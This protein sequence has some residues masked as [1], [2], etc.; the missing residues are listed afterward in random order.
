MKFSDFERLT[1]AVQYRVL[2][3]VDPGQGWSTLVEVL[4]HG[5]EG[6][7]S[8]ITDWL[9]PGLPADECRFVID[10]LAVYDALQRPYVENNKEVPSDLKFPGFDG[11]NES[12]L[13]GYFRFVLAQERF[14]YVKR[15]FDDGNS[16]GPFS[17]GYRR[18][19]S[20]WERLDK[21]P[22]LADPDATTVIEAGN[23]R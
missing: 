13:L 10:I 22:F 17:A 7:Y 19:V 5:Y 14:V 4:E 9:Y 23:A 15:M 6:E 1:L 12:H 11:N 20:A 8:R 18:M 3:K 21:P 16:H 2:D